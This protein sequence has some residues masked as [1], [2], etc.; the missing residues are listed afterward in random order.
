[1]AP[2]QEKIYTLE[3]IY[4]LSDGKRAELIDGHIYNMAP[5]TRIHQ[6]L[7]MNLSAQIHNY[8]KAHRGDCLVYPAPFAVFLNEDNLNYVEPDIS[9][10]YE[11]SKLTDKGC[12]GAPDLIIEI[13]SPSTQQ[14]DYGIKLFK[15]RT[16]GVREYWIINPSTRTVN[17]YDFEHEKG[18]CQYN[19][20]DYIPVCIYSDFTVQISEL[21]K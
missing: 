8:I 19:F 15:Y 9:V 7:V 3:D 4:S 21:L 5:P 16:A 2:Q 17:V 1:M 18:T 14:M 11:K 6:H 12:S 20:D 10:I 13:V